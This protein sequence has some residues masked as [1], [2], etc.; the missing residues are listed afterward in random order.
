MA[1]DLKNKPKKI[2]EINKDEKAVKADPSNKPK[3]ATH[4]LTKNKELKRIDFKKNRPYDK[5]YS[6]FTKK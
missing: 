3:G 1:D 6:Y 4:S 5:S 2:N